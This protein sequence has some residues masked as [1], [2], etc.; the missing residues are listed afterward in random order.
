MKLKKIKPLFTSIVTTMDKY[1]AE[2][3]N[4]AGIIDTSKTQGSIK[5]FQTVIAVGDAVKEFKPGDL[6]CINPARYAVRKYEENSIQNDIHQMNPITRFVF[7][8]VEL[9]GKECLLLDARDVMYIVEEL[10][11]EASE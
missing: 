10:V 6:V 7:K 4:D 5:E 9:N 11:D 3:V 2:V 1:D 8:T